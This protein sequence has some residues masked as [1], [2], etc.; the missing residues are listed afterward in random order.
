MLFA[1]SCALSAC[2]D[3]EAGTTGATDDSTTTTSSTSSST[4]TSAGTTSST[5][6]PSGSMTDVGGSTI[7]MTT[8][9][10][11]T[12]AGPDPF[13]G[14][15]TVDD[16]EECD[17]GDDNADDAACTLSCVAAFCGDGLVWA[18]NEECDDANDDNAD[19]C[20]EGCLNASCGDGF[21]GPGETCDDQNDVNDDDCSNECALAS[22]GDGLVQMGEECDDANADDS[23]ACLSTCTNAACGDGIVYVDNED[24]DD[25]NA[26]E[27]DDCT[28]LC[29]AP[30]CD[31]GLHSGLESDVDC[32][33]ADC[34]ACEVGADC[35]APVDCQ[36][37]ACEE[38]SCIIPTSCKAI[39]D[40]YPEATT[41]D[42]LVDLDA[43]GPAEPMMVHCDMDTDGGGWTLVQRTVWDPAQTDPLMTGYAEWRG[44]T[45][46]S[47][48]PDNGFRLAGDWWPTLN[49]AQDFMLIHHPRKNVGDNESCD[50]LYYIGTNGTITVDDNNATVLNLQAPVTM[51][52]N[53]FLS[54]NDNGP[55]Q[56]CINVHE[57]APWFYAGCCTT[58]PTFA[59]NY[60]AERHPMAS[61][62]A[63]TADFFGNTHAQNC[64]GDPVVLSLGYYGMNVMEFYL[65]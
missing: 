29:A 33:G 5:T 8:T 28:T 42:Y 26:D 63:S 50:P 32:G 60:F 54:T 57:G 17:D 37:L 49:V 56:F 53:S 39:K 2:G 55:S 34:D 61:Y 23:D 20:V 22:C 52:N 13:C 18:G 64:G 1:V 41:G 38:G 51:M 14:D 65:R 15:G 40:G 62:T 36:T 10:M 35:A 45:V 25:G 6:D 31:D 9:S 43:E 19:T 44:Q 46:G 3:S 48:A 11:P 24:C 21:V 30:T 16:G 7:M 47:I 27:F 12:T 59:G 58:C 4:S